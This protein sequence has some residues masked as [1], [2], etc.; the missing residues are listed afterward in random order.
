MSRLS[1][2][3]VRYVAELARLELTPAEIEAFAAQLSA[4]LEYA[5]ALQQVDTE[6]VPPTTS[7]LPLCNVMRADEPE[8]SLAVDEALANA[9]DRQDGYFRVRA[10]LEPGQ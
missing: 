6:H 5:A 7:V 9:P 8:P 1:T 3:E 10:V 4:V 2:D